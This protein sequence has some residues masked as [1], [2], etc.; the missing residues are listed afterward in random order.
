M[1]N[2][3]LLFHLIKK[4]LNISRLVGQ[5]FNISGDCKDGL[6]VDGGLARADQRGLSCS[7][8]CS[9]HTA[10]VHVLAQRGTSSG[11][12]RVHCPSPLL[13]YGGPYHTG[14]WYGGRACDMAVG[15][16]SS[17]ILRKTTEMAEGKTCFYYFALFVLFM[18]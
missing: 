5:S 7:N 8:R 4:H 18:Q 11:D 3:Y 13:W 17:T 16:K 15:K 9:P 2:L 10:Q 1:L 6:T 12:A 14:V